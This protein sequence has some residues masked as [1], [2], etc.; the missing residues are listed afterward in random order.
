MF[1]SRKTIIYLRHF[2]TDEN[3]H[4]F[5]S[6]WKC[7]QFTSRK[8]FIYLRHFNTEENN[9][10]FESILR[11]YIEENSHDFYIV[12]TIYLRAL[13]PITCLAQIILG[14]FRQNNTSKTDV[15]YLEIWTVSIK[16][17]VWYSGFNIYVFGRVHF[18]FESNQVDVFGIWQW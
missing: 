6:M 16:V 11:C 3:N 1:T 12:Q 2:N 15:W 4:L 13:D 9:H 7:L 18:M 10:L 14:A 17:C 5:E 8:T